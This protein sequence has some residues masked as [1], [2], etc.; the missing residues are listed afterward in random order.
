MT[1]S[2]HRP[3]SQTVGVLERGGV[4]ARSIVVGLLLSVGLSVCIPYVDLFLSCTF[5][6]GQ[7]LPPGAVFL[8]LVLVLVINPLL[9]AVGKRAGFSRRELLTIYCMLLFST[10]VPGH[11]AENVFM[12]VVVAPHYYATAANKWQELFF[13]YIP[14]WLTPHSPAAIRYFYEGLPPGRPI[15]YGEWMPTLAA[16]GVLT[17]LA[18]GLM[19]LLSVI[20]ARQW[21]DYEKL[22][23]PL[24]A[25]PL[26]MTSGA[27]DPGRSGTFFHDRLMWLGFG[28]VVFVQLLA[29]LHFYYPAFPGFKLE[30]DF[31]RIFREQ[32]LRAVGWVPGNIYPSVI[33]VSFLLRSEVSFSLWFFY[34]FTKLQRLVA[35][36]VGYRSGVVRTFS[37]DPAW[38]GLQP[39]GGQ[40]A[41]LA[42]S[43]WAGRR[44]FGLLW[45]RAVAGAPAAG[46]E[47]LSP[48]WTLLGLLIVVSGML[49]WLNAAGASLGA[50][51]YLVAY[52]IVLCTVLSKV[53]CESGL[54]FVQSYNSPLDMLRLAVG[55][56][57]VAARDLT[58]STFFEWSFM[59]DQRA[60]IMPSFLQSAK[61]AAV[62][63]LDHRRLLWGLVAATVLSL[64]ICYYMNLRLLYT[65]G[66]LACDPWFVKGAGPGGFNRLQGMLANP[67][68]GP[69]AQ[70]L[71]GLATGFALTLAMFRLRGLFL[72]FPFHPVGFIMMQTYPMHRLWFSIL[73]AWVVK[74]VITRYGGHK[75]VLRANSFFLGVIFGDIVMMVAWLV[76]DAIT[77][78]HGHFLLPS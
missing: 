70:A 69:S 16:W 44:Y 18:Y 11:G 74:V 66:G 41:Y 59:I 73:I 58:I 49:A 5:M 43:L 6:G 32:P 14:S 28:I 30:Y 57:N 12:S 52:Y 27:D 76:V 47:P 33:G 21:V 19:M 7:H 25:L 22:S 35:Y 23:F 24:V 8:L 48:R 53:V 72:W 2:S 29:G 64:G 67:T 10:L 37:G 15:P 45:R 55:T 77:Q 9:R 54:L 13:D 39:P 62:G 50:A 46:N 3:R 17:L 42:L 36:L 31:S 40:F 60:F 1:A 51:A 4:T 75:A 68:P 71:A 63:G 34:W 61:I 38:L 65:Y 78:T 26:E 56:R 20:L